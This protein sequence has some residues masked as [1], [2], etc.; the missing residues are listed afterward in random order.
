MPGAAGCD[1]CRRRLR[2][3]RGRV[4]SGATGTFSTEPASLPAAIRKLAGATSFTFAFSAGPATF[5]QTPLDALLQHGALH[6]LRAAG[7][8][9]RLPVANGAAGPRQRHRH[10]LRH[11]GRAQTAGPAQRRAGDLRR[12][13]RGRHLDGGEPAGASARELQSRDGR[14][15][16]E[17]LAERRL[18]HRRRPPAVHRRERAVRVLDADEVRDGLAEDLGRVERRAAGRRVEEGVD[19]LPLPEQDLPLRRL[20]GRRR[21]GMLAGDAAVDLAAHVG[22]EVE[23]LAGDPVRERVRARRDGLRLQRL[24]GPRARHLLRDD[25]LE[26][27]LEPDDVDR[28]ELLARHRDGDLAA[29]GP[30][31]LERRR[32][33]QE[34]ER[35]RQLGRRAV[36][37]HAQLRSERHRIRPAADT[38]CRRRRER[39]R[40]PAS[41]R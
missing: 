39:G 13:G 38:S 31:D 10:E 26:V 30:V 25:T 7:Q 36:D 19:R 41:G 24:V 32:T 9:D 35:S 15:Q 5:V 11:P 27:L 21:A 22:V 34:E 16:C 2:L 12:A 20:D 4:T 6:A 3:P 37:G 17:P 28:V 1:R 8:R 23:G 18:R 40:E 29:V 14:T 33:R